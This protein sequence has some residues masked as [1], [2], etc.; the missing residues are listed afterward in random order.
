MYREDISKTNQGGLKS[1]KKKPKEVIQYANE[2]DPGKCIVRLFKLYNKCPKNRPDDAFYLT[3][4]RR[5]TNE[6]WY[7]VTPLGHNPLSR[8][9]SELMSDGGFEGFYTNHS[10]RVTCATRL[11]E[12]QVDEQLIMGR[13]A[14]SSTDGVRAYKRSSKKLKE[15]TS[16]V[17]NSRSQDQPGPA[18][19]RKCAEDNECANGCVPTIVISGGTNITIN[20]GKPV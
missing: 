18:S 1:R 8:I 15:I 16:D 19:K 3:P 14:H 4:L 12:A 11:Y 2:K 17:L 13:T 20:I 5:P 6:V 7:S 9:V 10:L